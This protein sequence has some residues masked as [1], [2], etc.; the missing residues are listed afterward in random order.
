MTLN[1]LVAACNQKSSRDPVVEYEAEEVE[2]ALAGLKE[3]GWC[4]FVRGEGRVVKYAHR[5]GEN[6]VGLSNAQRAALSVL[7]LRGPQTLG[8]IKSRAL[9]QHDFKTL[10]EVEETLTSLQQ[11]E[12]PLVETAARQPGQKEER[13]RHC[14]GESPDHSESAESSMP[15]SLR[16][17]VAKL[18]AAL[19]RVENE[20]A[21]LHARLARLEEDFAK[22]RNDLY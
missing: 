5:A 17:E 18:K 3:K 11:W 16:A 22:M 4:A 2:E 7:L 8:E 10:E 9:R 1:A 20:N 13:Y 6:G 15:A 19:A 12:P 14:L 21:Q